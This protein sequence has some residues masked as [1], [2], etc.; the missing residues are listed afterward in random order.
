[1]ANPPAHFSTRQRKLLDRLRGQGDIRAV[2]DGISPREEDEAPVLSFSQ[3]R[4]WFL[5][6]LISNSP[7]YNV[8]VAVRLEGHLNVAAL[9]QSLTEIV[10]RHKVLRTRYELV[11]GAPLPVIANTYSVDLNFHDLASGSPTQDEKVAEERIKQ[12][13]NLPFDLKQGPVLRTSLYRLNENVHIFVVVIHH[14]AFD[15]WSASLFLTELKV[16]YSAYCEGRRSPLRELP[17]QYEDFAAWQRKWLQG[18]ALEAQL[19]YWT[20]QLSGIPEALAMPADY[21]AD[22]ITHRG[23]GLS[24]AL[25]GALM[26]RIAELSQ[27]EN[28][29]VFMTLLASFQLLLHRYSGQSTVIVGTP[30]ANRKQSE[31]EGL[32]GFFGNTLALRSDLSQGLTFRQLLR[33]VRAVTLDGYANQDLPFERLVQELHL[34]RTLNQHPVFQVMFSLQNL[35]HETLTMQGLRGRLIDTES[36]WVKFALHLSLIEQ[37]DGT[38]GTLRYSTDI[39]TSE[40]AARMLENWQCLMHEI[41]RN[42]DA[43]ALRLPLLTSSQREKVIVGWNQTQR[44]FDRAGWIHELFEQQVKA[45]PRNVALITETESLSYQELNSRSNRLAHRLQELNVGPE[46]RVGVYMERSADMVAALLAI[47]KA[48]GA[49]VPLDPSYPPERLEYMMKD[50][51]LE[52]VLTQQRFEPALKAYNLRL[53]SVDSIWEQIS[54]DSSGNLNTHLTGE[55][56]AYI[57]YTSGSTGQPK[58]AMNRHQG[59][60]NRLLWMQEYLSLTSADRILQKTPFS[61]DVSVWEFFWPL[62]AGAGLVMARPGGHQDGK[63]LKDVIAEQRITV[64]H[65]V[66]SMLEVFL[67]EDNL[68]SCSSMRHVICSGEALSWKLAERFLGR[69]TAELHNLYGPTEAAVDVTYWRCR[70][71][72]QLRKIPIGRPIAN[73]EMYVLDPELLPVPQGVNGELYIGGAGVGRGYWNKPQLTAERFIPH[74]FQTGERLYRTGDSGKWLSSGVI[75]YT[76]RVDHQIKLRGYRIELGEIE[77]ALRRHAH[78]RDAVVVAR[79]DHPGKKQLAA[80]LMTEPGNT[81]PEAD[82]QCFLRQKLPEYMIPATFLFLERFP[83]LANGKIDR[84]ALPA[85]AQS[86]IPHGLTGPRDAIEVELCN[87][88]QE[89]LSIPEVGIDQNFFALGGHSLSAIQLVSRIKKRLQHEIPVSALFQFSTVAEV[90][91]LVRKKTGTQAARALV[92]IQPAGDKPPFFWVHAIGGNVLSYWSLA[93]SLGTE[94]PFYGLQSLGLDGSVPPL[95]RISEMAAT[96]IDEIRTVQ[97]AGPYCLGGWS[98]GGLIAYEMAQ[99]LHRHDEQV[100]LLALID[101]E[102]PSTGEASEKNSAMPANGLIRALLP[103]LNIEVDGE[104]LAG[105]TEDQQLLV[106]LDAGKKTRRLPPD[107]SLEH[108]Q[109]LLRVFRANLTARNSY[110]AD[111]YPG[112]I[113]FFRASEPA[114]GRPA[115]LDSEWEKLALS[116]MEVY[117]IPGNHFTMLSHPDYVEALAATLRRCLENTQRHQTGIRNMTATSKQLSSRA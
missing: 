26:H 115:R 1:M 64:L 76:G 12:D 11:D 4:L 63:Y 62:L 74:P 33:Q 61:F 3:Q 94:Q 66:P 98:L 7:L 75:E 56:L 82:L 41:V 30:I 71:D 68:E 104:S 78:I 110:A 23:A 21:S 49:Y 42:A 46:S 73:L 5:D 97:P 38:T 19:S 70:R 111:P 27:S 50:A 28:A 48:G 15:G 39:F 90:A 18:A 54:H 60:R 25:S 52:L 43:E 35:R 58:G 89:V 57:I 108:G 8:P 37:P 101:T 6:Q 91:S 117:D 92:R 55:N 32:I 109:N 53:I 47:L 99:Q 95:N 22:K 16:L 34:D 24:F 72:S 20:R 103:N 93:S 2:S 79:E 114:K 112:K 67:E 113:T 40:T 81:L 51:A 10:R 85:P 87:I 45:A 59:I 116:G 44:E 36:E 107:F 29:S 80:Y 100:E 65:F 13:S 14:I 96:Y 9:Q 17:L 31:I 83:L 86:E 77:S 106:V 88:W 69:M 84:K 102:L 105:L